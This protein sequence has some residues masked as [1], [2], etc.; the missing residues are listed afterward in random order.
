MVSGL[1]R[2]G[3]A[4]S[5]PPVPTHSLPIFS[6]IPYRSCARS[7]RKSQHLKS[8]EG[9][10]LML[11]FMPIDMLQCHMLSENVHCQHP[12]I[13]LIPNEQSLGR[14]CEEHA[15]ARYTQREKPRA[16]NRILGCQSSPS[17]SWKEPWA[18]H[19]T[20]I[21]KS[22]LAWQATQPET[23]SRKKSAGFSLGGSWKPRQMK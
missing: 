6:Q 19:L 21:W 1:S 7:S 5:L 12:H 18:E 22:G 8:A 14:M 3:A 4:L 15:A 17:P 23:M 16:S 2:I 11:L 13:V 9:T 10:A 20:S